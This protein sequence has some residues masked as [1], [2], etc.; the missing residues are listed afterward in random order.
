MK[1]SLCFYF[2]EDIAENWYCLFLKCLI[3]F[4]IENTCAG[5]FFFLWKV[6]KHGFN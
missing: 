1:H 5:V 3:G 4:A 6:F 2:V